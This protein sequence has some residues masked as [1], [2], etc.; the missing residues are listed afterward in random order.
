[1]SDEQGSVQDHKVLEEQLAQVKEEREGAR[2][3]L[4]EKEF[5]LRHAGTQ[6]KDFQDQL[7]KQEDQIHGL[8][9]SWGP[10]NQLNASIAGLCSVRWISFWSNSGLATNWYHS[11]F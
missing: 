9:V 1:L 4:A 8:Q 11:E 3:L 5:E 10:S 6:I 2:A 7:I